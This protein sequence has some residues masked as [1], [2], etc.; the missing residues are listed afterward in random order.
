MITS[1]QHKDERT[2][3][4]LHS[5]AVARK[6]D[7][8]NIHLFI[9]IA[10][11]IGLSFPVFFLALTLTGWDNFFRLGHSFYMQPKPVHNWI[12]FQLSSGNLVLK[13]KQ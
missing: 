1:N 4:R 12:Y 11:V 9:T 6:Q 7:N 5:N 2:P 13:S 8:R 3:L 10:T